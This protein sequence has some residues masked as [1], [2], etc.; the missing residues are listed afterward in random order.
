[1]HQLGS[2]TAI[3]IGLRVLRHTCQTICSVVLLTRASE[4]QQS[5]AADTVTGRVIASDSSPIARAQVRL[6]DENNRQFLALSDSSGKYF[7][8]IA[9]GT[10]VYELSARAFGYVPL[11]VMVSGQPGTQRIARNLRLNPIAIALREVRVVAPKADKRRSTPGEQSTN[12]GSFL[13][14]GFPID[15]GSLTGV[16]EMEPG[17]VRPKP[18]DSQLS[19]AGQSPDQNRTVVD[20]ASFGGSRLPSEAVRS[21]GLIT[22]TYDVS[23]GGFSG[24]E[25]SATTISGTN[26]WGG[27]LDLQADEPGL[28]YSGRPE[29]Q[30]ANLHRLRLSG[31]GGGA[32]VRDK[33]FAYGAFDAFHARSPGTA[34]PFLDSAAL[35]RLSLAPDSAH[36]YLDIA[37]RLG[38]YS[39]TLSP[40]VAQQTSASI[41]SRFDLSITER[42]SLTARFDW[43][44]STF[45]GAGSGP[46]S[47]L[48][49]DG[50]LRTRNGGV[51]AQLTSSFDAWGNE[52][53]FYKSGGRNRVGPIS[54]QP[55]AQ[56]EVVSD[57]GNGNLG[58]VDLGL[59]GSEFAAVFPD[60]SH[61][62]VGDDISRETESRSHSFKAG[63][64]FHW[65]TDSFQGAMNQYGTF[66][67]KNLSDFENG[68]PASFTRTFGGPLVP[69]R[70][71]TGS[72]YVGDTWRPA[73]RLGIVY[74]VRWEAARYGSRPPPN[75]LLKPFL[76][77]A[78]TRPSPE[79]VTTPRLGFRY[80]IAGSGNWT[81]YG[82]IGRFAG[83]TDLESLSYRWSAT[84][85]S[86]STLSCIG[87]S[88]PSPNWSNYI[89]DPASSPSDCAGSKSAFS[90]QLPSALLFASD[91]GMPRNG[92][93]SFGIGGNFTPLWG[94]QLDALFVH[95]THLPTSIDN[96]LVS[97]SKFVLPEEANRPVYA[98]PS[99]IDQRTGQVS[100]TG[101]RVDPSLGQIAVLQS[102]G[103]SKTAQVT[104]EVGGLLKNTTLSLFYVFTHSQILSTGTP[105]P[106]VFASPTATSASDI[107]WVDHPFLPKH[108][109]E[110]LS[111]WRHGGRVQLRAI[112]RVSSGFAFT[113]LVGGDINGDT[114]QN[115]RAFVFDPLTATSS[116]VAGGMGRLLR[117][118]PPR[119]RTCLST[120]VGTIS[121]QGSCQTG[122][123]ASLDLRAQFIALGNVNTRRFLVTLT[124]T[125][126]PAALDYVLHGPRRIRGWGESREP[127][128][129]LLRVT[130]FDRA[131]RSFDYEV[132][133]NFG[134]ALDRAGRAPFRISLEGRLAFG[135]DPRYQ[136][137]LR[138]IEAALGNSP[139][140][141]RPKLAALIPN[142]PDALLQISNADPTGLE[143]TFAQRAQLEAAADSLRTRIS[144][145]I[146]LLV[147]AMTDRGPSIPRR[148][149]RLQ[150]RSEE[151]RALVQQALDRSRQILTPGQWK[152]VPF[153]LTRQPDLTQLERPELER[154][155][156]GPGQGF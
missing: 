87:P 14:E 132:N 11:S 139:Q 15:P 21:T 71:A 91:F 100:V 66:G 39:G 131:S 111:S 114:F 84:G 152:R 50:Q 45:S 13:S 37:K 38:L 121:R 35:L 25:V 103:E 98:D 12:W 40:I 140:A 130:G 95:S 145:A 34:L 96:N 106:G 42:H 70:R 22:N 120:Q 48:S 153:W 68:L 6:T 93:A 17:I 141:L 28:D 26:L 90:S 27:A 89:R 72:S 4:A 62:E 56:T 155:I 77:D 118:A 46:T 110:L 85:A 33:L 124:A 81:I 137:L 149:A 24:G 30:L 75:A 129:T 156:S 9:N 83:R 19:I 82:G 3:S 43:R 138:N 101:S 112:G 115:D 64:L 51:L 8:T 128:A 119:I 133:S 147:E 150:V 134:R 29:N 122:W 61:F 10:H 94:A 113:P 105:G 58:V 80:D 126:V 65:Q 86:D 125:N 151:A 2:G 104:A 148:Q 117:S 54:S 60:D 20:G 18:D 135:A 108:T 76:A 107:E 146:D 44:S 5:Q 16:A 97:V 136:P 49:G 47:L 36:R 142:V 74:G 88:A 1:M 63:I 73:P 144:T 109:F 7:I 92:R 127:D 154:T 143:L 67:F 41:L 52:L 99:S 59:G 55:S 79:V 23:H 102:R 78:L 31:G 123:S 32:L 116:A 57:L 53:R 69:V